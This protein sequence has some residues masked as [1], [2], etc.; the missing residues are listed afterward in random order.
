DI[1]AECA[2]LGTRTLHGRAEAERTRHFTARVRLSETPPAARAG[3]ALPPEAGAVVKSDTIYGLYFHGPAY[4]V[5]DR[6]W[7]TDGAVVGE[8]ATSLP[9][10]HSPAVELLVA[11][12]LLELAFQAAGLLEISEHARMGLPQRI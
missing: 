7:R 8:L 5:L 2:L 9:P 6:A 12:R 4:R 11:P 10:S 1:V 3:C